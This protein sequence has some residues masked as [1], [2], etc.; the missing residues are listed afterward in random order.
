MSNEYLGDLIENLL[1]PVARNNLTRIIISIAYAIPQKPPKGITQ[2]CCKIGGVDCTAYDIDKRKSDGLFV[3]IHG[4]GWCTG[5]TKYYHGI[6][7]QL[8][9]R[10][11][12]PAVS[13]DYRLA[14]EYQYPA[15]L[16]DCEAVLKELHYSGCDHLKYD[17]S[18]IILAGD[19][20]GGNLTAALCYRLIQNNEQFIKAQ[21]LI[22]PVTHMFNFHSPSYQEYWKKYAGTALLNPKH[23]A[24]WCLLYLGIPATK[25]NIKKLMNSQHLAEELESSTEFQNLIHYE[26]LPNE[27]K[28]NHSI[29]N[30]KPIDKELAEKFMKVATNPEISPLFGITSD[31]PTTLVLTAG[32]DI[33]RDEGIQYAQKLKESGV[34]TEWKHFPR[35]F[36]EMMNEVIQFTKELL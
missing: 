35:A 22:Y 15:G 27:F 19:S 30:R 17:K 26:N 33:L 36:H 4:G 34:K 10:M 11:G 7:Y 14:P 12:I 18:K 9:E 31:L 29:R 21:V 16:D 2:K 20:A 23:M 8:V 1:G 25:E 24:R 5:S 13:I 32:Y 3:F 28:E 6:L